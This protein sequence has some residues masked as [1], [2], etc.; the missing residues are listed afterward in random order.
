VSEKY[1]SVNECTKEI[2]KLTKLHIQGV[3]QNAHKFIRKLAHLSLQNTIIY[4]ITYF[5]IIFENK[6]IHREP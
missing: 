5:I 3:W 4:L 6:N 1:K 2:S